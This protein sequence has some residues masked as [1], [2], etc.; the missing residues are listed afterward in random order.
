MRHRRGVIKAAMNGALALLAKRTAI[1]DLGNC[2]GLLG[3]SQPQAARSPNTVG[4][5]VIS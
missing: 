5:E 3:L 4:E 1:V 2:R